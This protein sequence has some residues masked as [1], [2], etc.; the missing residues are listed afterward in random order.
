MNN[1]FLI[2]FHY[3]GSKRARIEVYPHKIQGAAILSP[4]PY[5]SLIS[6]TKGRRQSP[7]SNPRSKAQKRLQKSNASSD[8]R[9][10]HR[11][12]RNN[13]A[14]CKAQFG[15]C[16]LTR[17]LSS[18]YIFCTQ[19][20]HILSAQ[21]SLTFSQVKL[22]S[23]RRRPPSLIAPCTKKR[24]AQKA[25]LLYLSFFGIVKQTAYLRSIYFEEKFSFFAPKA[26]LHTSRGGKRKQKKQRGKNLPLCFFG[27]TKIYY[28]RLSG[29]CTFRNPY[30]RYG[31]W[32]HQQ[33]P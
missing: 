14:K 27:Y 20:P 24:G 3:L 10:N 22:H 9:Q 21:K 25:H 1:K 15:F 13:S 8:K 16:T 30:Q 7:P 17:F 18:V 5:R 28:R 19:Q 2:I 23:E 31:F 4:L 11:F 32:K 29:R 6:T 33:Q 26:Y 12:S